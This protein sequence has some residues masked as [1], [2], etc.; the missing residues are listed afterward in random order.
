MPGRKM[1]LKDHI[2]FIQE[3]DKAWTREIT[4]RELS[5]DELKKVGF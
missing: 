5:L 4:E 2:C 3:L 1:R